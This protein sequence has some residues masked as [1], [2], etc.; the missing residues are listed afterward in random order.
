MYSLTAI[1]YSRAKI[2]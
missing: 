1:R 2:Y